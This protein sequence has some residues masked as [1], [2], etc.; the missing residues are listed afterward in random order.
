MPDALKHLV[1]RVVVVVK[2]A[3]LWWGIA[4]SVGLAVVSLAVAA[5]VVVSWPP[6]NFKGSHRPRFWAGRHPALRILGLVGKNVAGVVMFLLGLVMALPGV[7]GQGFLTM[8]IAVTLVDFPGKHELERRLVGRPWVLRQ[9]NAIRR[10]FH[11]PPLEVH[12]PE[13]HHTPAPSPRPQGGGR[14]S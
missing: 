10:R 1:A 2:H 3:G 7:P 13:R 11:R 4:I 9:L 14:G 6:D 12:L 5:A 8:I